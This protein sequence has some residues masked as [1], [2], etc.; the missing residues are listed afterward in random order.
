MEDEIRLVP[1]AKAGFTYAGWLLQHCCTY[2]LTPQRKH[3]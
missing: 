1:D 3:T 2:V